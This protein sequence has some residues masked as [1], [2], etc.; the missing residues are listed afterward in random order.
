MLRNKAT[1]KL[2]ESHVRI[3]IKQSTIVLGMSVFARVKSSIGILVAFFVIQYVV[4]APITIEQ[5]KAPLVPLKPNID[6]N[7]TASE[8]YMSKI[9]KERRISPLVDPIPVNTDTKICNA[10]TA[11]IASNSILNMEAAGK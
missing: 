3:M 6:V 7:P 10:P 9:T 4:N 5:V 11:G 2:K 8:T 1:Q